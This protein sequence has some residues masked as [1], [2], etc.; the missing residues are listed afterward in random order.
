MPSSKYAMPEN[1]VL[2]MTCNVVL[3]RLAIADLQGYYDYAAQ[4]SPVDASRWLDR[5]QF[6]L[7]S[8]STRPDRCSVA[9]ENGKVEVELR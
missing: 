7:Q 9:R 6:A 1:M 3:Q 8:L 4:S 2:V 5:F